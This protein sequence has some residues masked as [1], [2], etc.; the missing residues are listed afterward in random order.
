[1]PTTGASL[2]SRFP[3]ADFYDLLISHAG[4]MLQDEHELG[5]SQV[6]N[7]PSPQFLHTTQV[8]GFK[9]KHIVLI[10][11]LMGQLKVRVTPLVCHPVMSQRQLAFALLTIV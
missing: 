1:M 2:A 4:N 9:P 3:L 6:A 7:F 8:E 11:K 5:E 10:T